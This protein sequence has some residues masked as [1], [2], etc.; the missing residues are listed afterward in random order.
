MS[1]SSGESKVSQKGQFPRLNAKYAME[2]RR[3]AKSNL[4]IKDTI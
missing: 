2:Q 1:L 3:I 4:Y